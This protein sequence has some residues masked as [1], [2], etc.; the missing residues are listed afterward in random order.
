MGENDLEMFHALK[1]TGTACHV[2]TLDGTFPAP[3]G[4]VVL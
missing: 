1:S 2:L 3:R 4:C